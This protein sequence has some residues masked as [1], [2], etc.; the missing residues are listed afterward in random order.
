MRN[1][2]CYMTYNTGVFL[3]PIGKL[4]VNVLHILGPCILDRSYVLSV[5]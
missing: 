2:K 4:F 1:E 5:K 3:E